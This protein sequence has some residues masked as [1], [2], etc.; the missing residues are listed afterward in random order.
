MDTQSKE[1]V[2]WVA[3]VWRLNSERNEKLKALETVSVLGKHN[4]I[5]PDDLFE[6]LEK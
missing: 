1:Y 3:N 5:L 4:G 2:E 6:L